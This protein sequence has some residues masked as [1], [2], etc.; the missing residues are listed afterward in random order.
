MFAADP[1]F[2]VWINSS[3][4]VDGGSNKY[5]YTSLVERFEGVEWQ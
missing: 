1:Q 2:K 4:M 5:S 3:R